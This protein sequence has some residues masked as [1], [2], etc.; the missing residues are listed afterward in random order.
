MDDYAL[1]VID[2][3]TTILLF[4][5]IAWR[6]SGVQPSYPCIYLL[7]YRPDLVLPFL[8]LLHTAL[9][10]QSFLLPFDP[11]NISQRLNRP[12]QPVVLQRWPDHK[13]H[14]FLREYIGTGHM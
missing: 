6:V 9:L 13:G 2:L 14:P 1:A 5:R 12:T 8:P 7:P 4:F 11:L 3:H 10:T